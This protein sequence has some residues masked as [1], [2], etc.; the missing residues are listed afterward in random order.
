M[1]GLYDKLSRR[2][3]LVRLRRWW[4]LESERFPFNTLFGRVLGSYLLGKGACQCQQFK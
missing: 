4:M 1:E 2:V 3:R